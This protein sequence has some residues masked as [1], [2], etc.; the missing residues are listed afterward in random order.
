MATPR[1]C[2]GTYLSDKAV[3]TICTLGTGQQRVRVTCYDS[4]KDITTYAYGPYV[5]V[6]DES[7][8]ECYGT[9]AKATDWTVQV[10]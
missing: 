9:Y 3:E 1:S 2:K 8:G 4:T 6:N 7:R 5:N 10:R